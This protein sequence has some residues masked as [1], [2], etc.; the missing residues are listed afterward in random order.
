MLY[1]SLSFRNGTW[2]P[3]Q[4]ASLLVWIDASDTSTVTES[5]GQVLSV[6]NKGSGSFTFS[7]TAGSRPAYTNTQNSKSIFTYT[8]AQVL[9]S[10]NNSPIAGNSTFSTICVYK[11]A[12]TTNGNAF[13]WGDAGTTLGAF[14]LYDDGTIRSYAY[15]GGNSFNILT[16]DAGWQIQVYVKTPGAIA[17]TSASWR[18][19]TTNSTS[20]HS[21]NTPNISSTP[22][23][24]G[25][26]ANYTFADRLVGD[27]AEFLVV[28]AALS[29]SNRQKLEGYLAHKWGLASNLPV[30]HPYKNQAP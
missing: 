5:A 4:L 1:P 26:W 22:F 3:L 6:T 17:S 24:L 23:Y 12:G 14:G 19:G 15:A 13:G 8:G 30:G 11:K 10:D 21:T 16:T 25:Q 2:T 9:T 18:D 7:S 20:G 29:T 27:I 28:S